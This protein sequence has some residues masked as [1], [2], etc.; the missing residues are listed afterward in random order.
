MGNICCLC[1]D[2]NKTEAQ[3]RNEKRLIVCEDCAISRCS[4]MMQHEEVTTFLE[5]NQC[6]DLIIASFNCKCGEKGSDQS[7]CRGSTPASVRCMGESRFGELQAYD[8]SPNS[9]SNEREVI[10]IGGSIRRPV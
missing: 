5:C 1:L 2:K 3:L 4:G 10:Q 8:S 6:S 9:S 7:L